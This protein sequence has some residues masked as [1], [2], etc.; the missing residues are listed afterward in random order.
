M[1]LLFLILFCIEFASC[2][3]KRQ[4]VK[5]IT[6]FPP[7]GSQINPRYS[8]FFQCFVNEG[9]PCLFVY[10]GTT[11]NNRITSD[12]YLV[13]TD[14]IQIS[15]VQIPLE[16]KK[17]LV[18]FCAQ[19]RVGETFYIWGGWQDTGISNTLWSFDFST[20]IWKE[21][22]QGDS[23]PEARHSMAYASN[24][25]KLY[26]F[27]GI[28]ASG[29]MKDLWEFDSQAKQWRE[30]KINSGEN[31]PEPCSGAGMLV[32]NGYAVV[33][34]GDNGGDVVP[35]LKLF[36]VKIDTA[37]SQ[38]WEK[39][40]ITDING[41]ESNVPD[42]RANFGH[43]TFISSSKAHSYIFGGWQANNLF[44]E[45]NS[46][47]IL[48][49]SQV[50]S[51]GSGEKTARFKELVFDHPPNEYY[52]LQRGDCGCA[53]DEEGN[54]FIFG[55]RMSTRINS[56]IL[57]VM[58]E[59][60]SFDQTDTGTYSQE[61][62]ERRREFRR[63]SCNHNGL[64]TLFGENKNVN[65]DEASA[66]NSSSSKKKVWMGIELNNTNSAPIFDPISSPRNANSPFQLLIFV[67]DFA[68]SPRVNPI[69]GTINGSL[70][71]YGGRDP[72][73]GD[74]FSD[75]HILMPLYSLWLKINVGA[76]SE[77]PPARELA[78]CVA[79]NGRLLM[80]GGLG[81]NS[82]T[83][84]IE[85]SNELWEFTFE[86]MGWK[87]LG[88]NSL[89]KP[90]PVSGAA[91]AIYMDYLIALGGQLIDGT[92]CD[93]GFMFNFA[94]DTWEFRLRSVQLLK[95]SILV[96]DMT[97]DSFDPNYYLEQRYEMNEQYLAST[98]NSTKRNEDERKYKKRISISN[99]NKHNKTA[100]QTIDNNTAMHPILI[101]FGGT[102]GTLPFRGLGVSDLV[103]EFIKA[104][105]QNKDSTQLN[106]NNALKFPSSTRNA[107]FD[108][109]ETY[110]IYHYLDGVSL[111]LDDK[112]LMFGG[113]KRDRAMDTFK[114][115]KFNQN[116]GFDIKEDDGSSF[117]NGLHLDVVEAGCTVYHR[118]VI[119]FGGR[120]ISKGRTV[121]PAA[122]DTFRIIN[123]HEDLFSCTP[124]SYEGKNGEC[125]DCPMGSFSND[126]GSK[127]CKKCRAGTVGYLYG[128]QEFGCLA[129]PE[130][131]YSDTAGSISTKNCSHEQYCPIGSAA[132]NNK[133]PTADQ[134][135]TTQPS[136]Y[137]SPVQTENFLM[138]GLYIGFTIIGVVVALL[139]LCLPTRSFVYKLDNFSNKY[140]DTL[141]PDTHTTVKHIKKTTF[142]GFISIVAI[143]FVCGAALLVI[144]TFAFLN[145]I[146]T[147]T[148]VDVSMEKEADLVTFKN[149]KVLAEITLMDY[150]GTCIGPPEDTA[151][152]L[153]GKCSDKLGFGKT[154]YDPFNWY[155]KKDYSMT[156]KCTQIPS[157][158]QFHSPTHHCKIT[159]EAK[160]VKLPI[161]N[162]LV[163]FF[164]MHSSEREASCRAI[165]VFA[166][167]DS[168]VP[169]QHDLKFGPDTALSSTESIFVSDTAH[170]LRGSNPTNVT[171]E[172][173]PSVYRNEKSSKP[174]VGKGHLVNYI[175]FDIGSYADY[176]H[177][178]SSMG[179]GINI[180]LKL[181]KTVALTRHS[182][183]VTWS[184]LLTSLGG[185]FVYLGY[186]GNI[187]PIFET[188][189]NINWPCGRKVQKKIT[190]VFHDS[191]KKGRQT[192]VNR[193]YAE[194]MKNMME[195][196]LT[197]NIA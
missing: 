82:Q 173:I 33:Y 184:M 105:K 193:E 2:L 169:V 86:T 130:G 177:L 14:N 62:N 138:V 18:R 154:T 152:E 95:P 109:D 54:L 192:K 59:D 94:I 3:T 88:K 119:C 135:K 143:F 28:S 144:L 46:L 155:N 142:G 151:S 60:L 43:A 49:C 67:N 58:K 63:K 194:E 196:H 53:T 79:D 1:I 126:Y 11:Y 179:F 40:K 175:S 140:V 137:L 27:G 66:S 64:E 188:L 65:S 157:T 133:I 116:G 182:M 127:E 99:N 161:Q 129:V 187:L 148:T 13:K 21:V 84:K 17:P 156:P 107:N 158:N 38:S 123:L 145:T 183:K 25:D 75:I 83:G 35:K 139:L 195:E 5:S 50:V 181:D 176:I 102:R 170:I 174:S 80:F 57:A 41:N 132:L 90:F 117:T 125:A 51:S 85:P 6:T 103:D 111:P 10:G 134:S 56:D 172:L 29:L 106:M 44:T 76:L 171:V 197:S 115:V 165:K 92:L 42:S 16:S 4:I 73:T 186:F 162:S 34:G 163:N 8:P 101:L 164:S 113:R 110:Q 36:R 47:L 141:D 122:L 104:R 31:D 191:S 185:T 146:E 61:A 22:D 70:Y 19:F 128:A 167:T 121:T 124:G 118:S 112:A 12:G 48:D 77:N 159:L 120:Q 9:V 87:Q 96:M 190:T 100:G 39:M 45:L 189:L 160:N 68:P 20:C 93:V 30:L 71:V 178:S 7:Y 180:Q 32:S 150:T 72:I 24:G 91:I 98:F 108:E 52:A 153:S 15:P 97:V 37:S 23:I 78:S 81:P 131:Y 166:S 168:A 147:R 69:I 136:P 114:V 55:G 149:N 26:I 74:I 89:I